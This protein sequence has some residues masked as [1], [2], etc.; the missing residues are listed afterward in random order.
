MAKRILIVDDEPSLLYSLSEFLT[1]RG[2]DVLTASNGVQALQALVE[3]PPDLIISDILMAEMDGFAFQRRVQALTGTSIPFIFLTAKTDFADRLAGLKG[4][5]DDYITKPF[6]PEELVMR[7]EAVLRRVEQT[8]LEEQRILEAERSRLLAQVATQLRG[9]TEGV[10][11]KLGLALKDPLPLDE[12]ERQRYLHEALHEAETLHKH[13]QD[14]SWATAGQEQEPLHKERQRF[15]PILRG[16]AARVAR[17]AQ[18]R[19]VTLRV[20]C[21]GLLTATVDAPALTRALSALLETAIQT[22]PSGEQISISA[23]RSEEGGVEITIAYP[24]Q[25][26]PTWESDTEEPPAPLNALNLARQIA[27]GHGGRLSILHKDDTFCYV[28]WIPGRM[29]RHVAR[30]K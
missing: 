26:A 2:F 18:K 4:G 29:V 27:Q 24:G 11:Q 8:R 16:A 12:V 22:L 14:L 17:L 25:F 21:G 9:P 13:L 19:G 28:L 7:I 6:D 5:A 15:A 20:S 23:V 1:R 30:R 3:A 10:V